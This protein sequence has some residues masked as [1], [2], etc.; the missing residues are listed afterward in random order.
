MQLLIVNAGSAHNYHCAKKGHK[1]YEKS[2][3]HN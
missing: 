2:N 1:N 3:T